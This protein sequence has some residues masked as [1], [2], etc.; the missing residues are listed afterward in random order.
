MFRQGPITMKSK[1]AI[2]A[3]AATLAALVISASA[4]ADVFSIT[5]DGTAQGLDFSAV[6]VFDSGLPNIGYETGNQPPHVRLYGGMGY[7]S[8]NIASPLIAASVT[9]NGQQQSYVGDWAGIY[10]VVDSAPAM[11]FYVADSTGFWFETSITEISGPL[12]PLTFTPFSFSFGPTAP[13]DTNLVRGIGNDFSF[14]DGTANTITLTEGNALAAS[15]V[16]GPIVGAGIPGLMLGA[17]SVLG[18]WRRRS[19]SQREG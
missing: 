16:P 18:W 2:A 11:E 9:Y 14:I 7:G 6:Y 13:H 17:L 1:T 19:E 4:R 15:P 5:V 10:S 8:E 3:F 12:F